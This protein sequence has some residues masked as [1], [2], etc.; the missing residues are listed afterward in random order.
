MPQR[1]FTL[2]ELMVVLAIVGILASVALPAYQDY[3]VR[4]R[5]SEGLGLASAAK[6][7]VLDMVNSGTVSTAAQGYATGY[8]P[9]AATQNVASLTINGTSGVI[10]LTTAAA[11]GGGSVLL[12]PFT[13]DGTTS[14]ALP[15]PSASSTLVQGAV[16]WKCLVEGASAFVGVSV[17]SNAL[18]AK[19]A[20]AQCR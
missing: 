13:S 1:G 4:A 6:T 17:A 20:P 18:P 7:H 12:V 9:P 15:A 19:Y 10:T 2:I 11:A 16:Q 14:S 5:V 8:S 3:T